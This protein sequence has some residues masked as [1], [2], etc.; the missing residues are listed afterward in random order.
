MLLHSKSET[1]KDRAG[2]SR[3]E[4]FL[5][6]PLSPVSSRVSVILFSA[7]L[8]A[9]LLLTIISFPS[10]SGAVNFP[11]QGD[12]YNIDT[13]YPVVKAEYDSE[14][15]SFEATLSIK[16][17]DDEIPLNIT[18]E[19]NIS[20][21]IVPEQG[22]M[23]ENYTLEL[24]V[25]N[26]A[27][28][29]YNI[30]HFQVVAE[31]MDIWVNKPQLG[32]ANHSP[33]YLE[34]QT[35]NRSYCKYGFQKSTNPVHSFDEGE[36]LTLLHTIGNE[37]AGEST[38]DSKIFLKC[39]DY[40]G[41]PNFA[42][43][44]V[45]YD[46]S[47]PGITVEK[48][49]EVVKDVDNKSI[50][51]DIKTEDPTLCQFEE[52]FDSY[53]TW[54]NI[55][56]YKS[57]YV[58][59][60]EFSRDFDD[61]D[62]FDR[63]VF[64]DNVTCTNLAG[65]TTKKEVA[66]VVELSPD[67]KMSMTNPSLYTQKTTLNFTVETETTADCTADGEDFDKDGAYEH[68]KQY[69]N[70]KDGKYTVG[71]NC[72]STNV[73]NKRSLFDFTVDTTPPSDVNVSSPDP[74]CG[75][76]ATA[77]FS[78]ND[79]SGINF[80]NYTLR[81]GDKIVESGRT[82]E[83]VSV[84]IENA[85][86]FS[87]SLLSWSAYAVDV[88]GN[89]G[90]SSSPLS[91]TLKNSTSLECDDTPPVLSLEK[92]PSSD[93]VY[94]NVSCS[95]DISGCNPSFNYGKVSLNSQCSYNSSQTY[96][97]L[98]M[99]QNTAKVCIKG[100]DN[101][102]NNASIFETVEVE[103]YSD[104]CSDG[105]VSGNETSVDCGGGCPPCGEGKACI[106]DSD[107]STGFCL[108]SICS[109]PSCSDQIMNGDETDVDCGGSCSPCSV[110]SSCVDHSDCSSNYC[111]GG[112]CASPSCSDNLQ[113]GN[114]TDVDCGGG[115]C[116]LCDLD[117]NCEVDSDCVSDF[118]KD[119]VCSVDKEKDTDGDGIPDFWEENEGLDKNDPSDAKE[120]ID[121]DGLTNL[122]EYKEETD[123]RVADTD[124]DEYYD[125]EEVDEG[126]DPLDPE[127]FPETSLIAW[128]VLLTGLVLLCT[129]G[130][131]AYYFYTQRPS[132]KKVHLGGRGGAG[133]G[134]GV[135]RP[136]GVGS[137]GLS[138]KTGGETPPRPQ[139]PRMKPKRGQRGGEESSK[140]R[141]KRVLRKPESVKS[142]SKM[143]KFKE[144]FSEFGEGEEKEEKSQSGEVV[145]E[146]KKTKKKGGEDD[147]FSS[148]KEDFE[149][150]ES[151]ETSKSPER[152]EKR[153]RRAERE[154]PGAER[155]GEVDRDVQ[156]DQDFVSMDDLKKEGSE[157]G[158]EDRE[159]EEKSKKERGRG[160]E[161]SDAISELEGIAGDAS[162]GGEDA[163]EEFDKEG[164]SGEDEG[165]EAMSE[166]KG[167]AGE[168]SDEEGE[169]GDDEIEKY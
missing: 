78:A 37:T 69:S 50:A 130:G 55:Y 48:S 117:M 86:N 43:V 84:E 13:A 87:N 64:K 54:Q 98:M 36:N 2:S 24:F 21:S 104:S 88:A 95:D 155:R 51:V 81:L 73:P 112:M 16:G 65:L 45:G 4:T 46:S 151:S 160:E 60:H 163:E 7:L 129:G 11:N 5:S 12:K 62:D 83:S 71:V 25:E 139:K 28:S 9:C 144:A 22:L 57:S 118:C 52:D 137:E 39:V 132:S 59:N 72:T 107:C 47:P 149:G 3:E 124:G 109:A 166:L 1:T 161:S 106:D 126:T 127:S 142:G 116:E 152:V 10:A 113:D 38:L 102:D 56:P 20:F 27:G 168:E 68:V 134:G 34:I 99:V 108:D 77:T 121:D 44:D 79:T 136:G 123:I 41:R 8:L 70:L 120:D 150:G 128:I 91:V 156:E 138:E 96:D 18:T 122:E 167:I 32:V 146:Q 15:D 17:E 105:E 42:E 67:I 94:V 145:D 35:E 93:G 23:N 157:K 159:A 90:T 85:S 89:E 66:L 141:K 111:D 61:I 169:E 80:Y 147:L 158:G 164:E 92:A 53:T 49:P 119:G 33:Y 135:G 6:E 154:E 76:P 19:D 40:T 114:E 63:H 82:G 31:Y 101:M 125:G 58:E 115:K 97:S 29:T 100:K 148:F 30:V 143:D 153:S 110:N 131:F 14:V 26:S 140:K 165:S 162:S 74:V 75:S 133:E 103:S